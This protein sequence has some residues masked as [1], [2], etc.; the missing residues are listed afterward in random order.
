[1]RNSLIAIIQELV[2]AETSQNFPDI[3][4]LAQLHR[5]PDLVEFTSCEL[6]RGS[7][8]M[9]GLCVDTGYLAESLTFCKAFI[10]TPSC[11][12]PDNPL[13]PTWNAAAKDALI[14]SV[15]EEKIARRLAQEDVTL[16]NVP[17]ANYT[18]VF[19]TGNHD[20][21]QNFKKIS[22]LINFPSCDAKRSVSFPMCPTECFE[23]FTAC[24]FDPS[25][26]ASAC[27]AADSL[28]PFDSN[29][30]SSLNRTWSHVDDV[31]TGNSAQ[32]SGGEIYWAIRLILFHLLLNGLV[33]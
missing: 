15:V 18:S 17:N 24:R 32:N 9:A 23:Y 25:Y 19:F 2:I 4:P 16:S 8:L 14:G 13:W 28:W 1:M 20:C 7:G 11:V 31:C 21:V 3:T 10:L 22:C 12:P 30:N 5:F 26:T 6:P 27:S 33:N 29:L